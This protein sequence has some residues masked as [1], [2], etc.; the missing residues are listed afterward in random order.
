[1]LPT[2]RAAKVQLLIDRNA[3]AGALIERSRAQ[4]VIVGFGDERTLRMQFVAE[5]AEVAV[6]DVV[7]TSGIDGIYPKGF[8]IGLVERVDKSG[9][10]YREIAVKPAVDYS[11]LEE[12]LVVLTPTPSRE[13]GEERT[14]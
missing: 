4:G 7:V 13:A 1:V 12:L 3:A 5:T 14:R 2:A 11:R 10:G 8:A 9:V 6:G